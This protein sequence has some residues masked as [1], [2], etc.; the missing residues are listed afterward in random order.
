LRQTVAARDYDVL[1]IHNASLTAAWH[2]LDLGAAQP[3]VCLLSAHDHWLTCPLSSLWKFD[4]EPCQQRAC[5]ACTLHAGRPPQLW[6][7]GGRRL[8]DSLAKLDALVF[9]SAH[10]QQAHRRRGIDHLNSQVLPYFIPDSW[11]DRFQEHRAT[12]VERAPIFAAVGRLVKEKGFQDVIEQMADLPAAELHIAGAGPY[13]PELR[14][15]AQAL[16]NVK[17][18]GWLDEVRLAELYSRARALVVP[19]LF[20]ETFGYV[21]AEALAARTPCIVRDRGALPDS[22]RQTGGGR[23]FQSA[24]DLAAGLRELA[25]DAGLANQLGQTGRRQA[26]RLWS[27]QAHL[28]RYLQLIASLPRS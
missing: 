22:I 24:Q 9:P 26:E 28:E 18:L 27:E 5:L 7:I 6:R 11:V 16:P 23:I 17:F 8:P 14:R 10:A 1:H 12:A 21:V 25:G 15:L 13:E 20:Y 19:S 3:P 2:A 4:R